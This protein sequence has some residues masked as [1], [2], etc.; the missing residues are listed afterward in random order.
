MRQGNAAFTAGD[1]DAALGFYAQAEPRAVDPGLVA[2]NQAAASF[3]LGR[4]ADAVAGYRQCLEDDQAP[5]RARRAPSTTLAPRLSSRPA[6]RAPACWDKPWRAFRACLAQPSLDADLAKDARHNLELAQLLWLQA[7]AANPHEEAGDGGAQPPEPRRFRP[8]AADP[9]KQDSHGEPAQDG[10]DPAAQP[11]DDGQAKPGDGARDQL[12]GGPRQVLPDSD[13]VRP[14]PPA[15]ADELL[16][17]IV[18]RI[19]GERRQ[20]WQ[21]SAPSAKNARNW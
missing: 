12:H 21:Q 6:A 16:A 18:A 5:R 14:L 17:R 7:R 4:F 20:H 11:G 19:A 9:Q 15:D 2:F 10:R 13:E 1:F 8:G 3:R